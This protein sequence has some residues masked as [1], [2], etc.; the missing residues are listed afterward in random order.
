RL[1]RV[2]DLSRRIR[3]R[4]GH[5]AQNAPEDAVLFVNLHPE[6][7]E[8]DGLYARGTPFN[9]YAHRIVLEITERASLEGIRDI[10]YRV[11]R[12]RALRFRLAVDD[13]RTAY[14]GLTTLARIEPDIVKLDMMLARGLASKQ[15]N[16]AVVRSMVQLCVELGMGFVCEGVETVAQRDAMVGLGCDLFQGYLYAPPGREFR[17]ADDV[18]LT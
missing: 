2:D 9:R 10:D 18:G 8:D 15:A 5:D 17:N 3:F 16:V 11:S 7:L 6:D 13:P 12:L 4:V 1:K 14:S